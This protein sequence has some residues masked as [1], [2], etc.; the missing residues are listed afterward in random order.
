MKRVVFAV[1]IC[2]S[3]AQAQTSE[4]YLKLESALR[5]IGDGR[6]SEAQTELHRA[7]A[8][9]EQAAP[10]P[11]LA[12]VL[13]DL[14]LTYRRQNRL[15]EASAYY[16][17]ALVVLRK[18]APDTELATALHNLGSVRAAEGKPA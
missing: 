16:E 4:I 12:T 18:G 10:C 14:A 9:C 1:T 2:A 11:Q 7:L 15:E 8:V 13:N 3:L 6:Y 17:R 5:W